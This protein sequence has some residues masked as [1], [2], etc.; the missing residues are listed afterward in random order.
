MASVRMPVYSNSNNHIMQT[1]QA[2]IRV[3]YSVQVS[4]VKALTTNCREERG[5]DTM[6]TLAITF[7]LHELMIFPPPLHL[8]IGFFVNE[9]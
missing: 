5:C 7:P 2:G 8:E 1:L 4:A 6:Q 3:T 9:S